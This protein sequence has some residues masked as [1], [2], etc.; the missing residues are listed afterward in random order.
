MQHA[1]DRELDRNSIR[2]CTQSVFKKNEK[3]HVYKKQGFQLKHM[4]HGNHVCR[5]WQI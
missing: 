1:G 3:V 5:V 2:H 4:K